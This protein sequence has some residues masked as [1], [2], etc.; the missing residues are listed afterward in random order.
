MILGSI[1]SKTP[2]VWGKNAAAAYIRT[3]PNASQKNLTIGA[4]SYADGFVPANFTPVAAGGVPPFGQDMNGVLQQITQWQQ[5]YQAGGTI[6]FDPTF[7]SVQGI[8]GYPIRARVESAVTPYLIWQSTM[9]NNINNPDDPVVAKRIGWQQPVFPDPTYLG[10]PSFI[11]A[12]KI[13]GSANTVYGANIAF[14]G[15]AK[16]SDGVTNTTAPNKFLR[17]LN[18]SFRID[19]NA[20]SAPIFT[21]TDGGAMTVPGAINGASLSVDGNVTGGSL[22][23][24]GDATVTGNLSAGSVSTNGATI[25]SLHVTGN[26]QIDASLNVNVNVV[27]GAGLYGGTFFSPNSFNDREWSFSVDGNGSKYQVYRA[28]WYDKWDGTSGVRSWVIPSGVGM[29]L[30]GGGLLTTLNGV[31]TSGNMF[32][33]GQIVA[34]TGLYGGTWFSPNAYNNR[35]WT[36]SVD[37]TPAGGGS[38][39]QIYRAGGWYDVWEGVG[40]RRSWNGPPGSLMNLDGAG[41]LNVLGAL[42]VGSTISSGAI[43]ANGTINSQ[44]NITANSGRL[45]ASFGHSNDP[46]GA[47][48]LN[49]FGF[50]GS[51]GSWIIQWPKFLMV[52][53][54]VSMNVGN[55]GD[56]S[57]SFGATAAVGFGWP[58]AFPN[59]CVAAWGVGNDTTLQEGSE[60]CIGMVS[61]NQFGGTVRANR[62]SGVNH[63][64]NETFTVQIIGIGW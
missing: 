51:F 5:W 38:K 27:A 49:D 15:N 50:A 21:L 10:I 55:I 7:Q 14:Y 17:A 54:T 59:Q 1:P 45:R 56:G 22:T 41:N 64:G 35:E 44:G 20:Y 39:V 8:N 13:D 62:T 26:A 40:G 53:T 37:T 23:S 52:G 32:A 28:S 36:F 47:P 11:G 48:I 25:G 34:T 63:D 9:D 57:S 6:I 60:M 33:N 42:A 2:T 29:S 58:T 3:V 18:G 19:N 4:A 30:D 61:F 31:N 43:N 12:L 46:Q 16:L 24:L